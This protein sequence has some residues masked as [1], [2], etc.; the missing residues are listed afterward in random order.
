V[1][2]ESAVW[3]PYPYRGLPV[4]PSARPPQIA[5][6]QLRLDWQMW[7]AAMASPAEYPWTL[8]LVWKLLQNDPGAVGLFA[9]NP[10]PERPP[11]YVRAVEYRYAFADPANRGGAWWTRERLGHLAPSAFNR[12]RRS[13][14]VPRG[15]AVVDGTGCRAD[16]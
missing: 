8:H 7:F 11:R 4:D 15:L 1:P 9:A 16:R 13:Q 14:A 6:Y 5:P 2:D 12:I 3:K 10:F